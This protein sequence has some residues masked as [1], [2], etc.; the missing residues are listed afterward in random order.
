MLR[1]SESEVL[2]PCRADYLEYVNMLVSIDHLLFNVY[3]FIRLHYLCA[4]T[5]MNL[6][7]M[8]SKVKLKFR[9]T[10]SSTTDSQIPIRTR[11]LKKTKIN[12]IVDTVSLI[13][14]AIL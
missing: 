3:A 13:M 7:L 6:E 1:P 8:K 9:S 11:T 5:I 12:N 10:R 4:A 2:W 14:A